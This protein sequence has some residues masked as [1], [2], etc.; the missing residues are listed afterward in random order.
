MH[1]TLGGGGGGGQGDR[2]KEAGVPCA[3]WWVTRTMKENTGGLGGAEC[4]CAHPPR[5]ALV[6]WR[7]SQTLGGWGPEGLS[8]S[9][10]EG[11]RGPG[12]GQ[13]GQVVGG[14]ELMGVGGKASEAV[15]A[16]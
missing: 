8:R 7:L 4:C 16:G 12:G 11:K 14:Q 9:G 1:L 3:K 6:R 15:G 10:S 2:N 13:R 5:E